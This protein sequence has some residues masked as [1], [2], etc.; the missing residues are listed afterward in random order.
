MVSLLQLLVANKVIRHD[1]ANLFK[2]F[3]YSEPWIGAIGPI[4][5]TE[6]SIGAVL[7]QGCLRTRSEDVL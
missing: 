5:R 4:N 2:I 6:A 1:S 7:I 3:K